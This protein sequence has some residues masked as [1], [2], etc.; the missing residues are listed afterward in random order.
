MS[1]L[2]SRW[3]L[4]ILNLFDMQCLE[5]IAKLFCIVTI[6]SFRFGW[7]SRSV[8]FTTSGY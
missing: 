2:F 3:L 1:L 5:S 8:S 4:H 7:T 6:E